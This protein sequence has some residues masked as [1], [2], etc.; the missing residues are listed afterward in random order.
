MFMY[1]FVAKFEHIVFDKFLISF[2]LDNFDMFMYAFVAKF[3]SY[4]F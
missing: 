4:C 1:S 2:S 3:V